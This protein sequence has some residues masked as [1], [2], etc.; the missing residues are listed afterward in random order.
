MKVPVRRKIYLPVT[1]GYCV[2]ETGG[3]ELPEVNPQSLTKR[4]EKKTVN[5]I[6]PKLI[7]EPSRVRRSPGRAP[8][9]RTLGSFR[10]GSW[11][12]RPASWVERTV[13]RKTM[14][15][16]S[17]A[18]VGEGRRRSVCAISRETLPGTDP[19]FMSKRAEEPAGRESERP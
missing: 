2:L 17:H 7:G 4:K 19:A 12:Q 18:V 6:R 8:C 9:P 1:E 16:M 11:V 5:S 13:N 10:P 15:G 3:G 14:P